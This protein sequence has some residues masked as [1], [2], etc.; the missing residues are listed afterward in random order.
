MAIKPPVKT[1]RKPS[2][3]ANVAKLKA[4]EA[5]NNA[6]PPE[7]EIKTPVESPDASVAPWD[8]LPDTAPKKDAKIESDRPKPGTGLPMYSNIPNQRQGIPE[9]YDARPRPSSYVPTAQDTSPKTPTKKILDRPAPCS[10]SYYERRVE[11]GSVPNMWASGA[12]GIGSGMEV[13]RKNNS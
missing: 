13:V 8:D 5:R 9:V 3:L 6:P 7:V 1:L 10:G 12:F 2:N 11:P 4:Q